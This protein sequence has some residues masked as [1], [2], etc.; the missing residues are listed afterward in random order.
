M[1]DIGLR[2]YEQTDWPRLC[3]IHDAARLHELEASGLVSAFLTLEQT[4]QNEGLFDGTIVVCEVHGTVQGFAAVADGEL[5]WLYVDP[6][7]ARQGIGRRLLRHVIQASGGTLS[8]EVLLGNEPAL[9]L[10][11]SEGFKMLRRVDGKLAGNESFAAS[12]YALA[13]EATMDPAQP[14]EDVGV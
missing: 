6:A 5:T 3:A 4:A 12:G 1:F 10:Y 13:R 9:A 14:G 7:M 11:L 8:T 2:A